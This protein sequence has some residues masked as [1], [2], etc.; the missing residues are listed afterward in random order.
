MRWSLGEWLPSY[1]RTVVSTLRVKLID[2]EVKGAKI[3]EVWKSD[4]SFALLDKILKR[5]SRPFATQKKLIPIRWK[6]KYYQTW[7]EAVVH[8]RVIITV[9][10]IEGGHSPDRICKAL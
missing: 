4:I 1:L 8:H 2:T 10:L 5:R 6:G 7:H 3:P 9:L